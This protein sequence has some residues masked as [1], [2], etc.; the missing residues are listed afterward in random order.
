M[1]YA[2]PVLYR[3]QCNF[4]VEADTPEKAEEIAEQKFKNGDKQ[5]TLGNEWEEVERTGRP[6][7][8][9]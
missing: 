9:D 2:V 4:L 1:K 6:Q 7:P 5:D 3:G 8:L